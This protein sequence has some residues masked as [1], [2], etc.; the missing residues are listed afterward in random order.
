[1]RDLL[2]VAGQGQRVG[3]FD[4]PALS[5]PEHAHPPLPE[6]VDVHRLHA[7][8][9]AYTERAREILRSA[10]ATTEGSGEEDLERK[11]GG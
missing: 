10:A 6:K 9:M 11:R 2:G 1:M 5:R 8:S 3:V 4:R 7:E